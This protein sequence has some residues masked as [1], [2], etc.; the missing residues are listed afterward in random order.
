M[1]EMKIHVVKFILKTKKSCSFKS[2]NRT[3]FFVVYT[4]YLPIR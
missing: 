3:T 2:T 4:S 1:F